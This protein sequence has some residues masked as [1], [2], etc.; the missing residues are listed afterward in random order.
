VDTQ[1]TLYIVAKAV[2][3]AV[4]IPNIPNAY[5][6]LGRLRLPCLDNMSPR[7]ENKRTYGRPCGSRGVVVELISISVDLVL[8]VT[9]H[10]YPGFELTCAF[11]V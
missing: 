8:Q 11:A 5:L 2:R 7:L 9:S 1:E 6:E 4:S 10:H 3:L